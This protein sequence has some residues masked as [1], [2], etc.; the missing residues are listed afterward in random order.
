LFLIARFCIFG[1]LLD[2][3]V[4]HATQLT[5]KTTKQHHAEQID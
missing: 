2:E 4:L 3:L 5:G 1:F